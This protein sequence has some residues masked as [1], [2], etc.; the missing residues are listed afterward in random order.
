MTD[1][2][3]ALAPGTRLDEFEIQRVL[4]SGGFG[5]TYLA[6]DLRL[7]RL[8]A[9]KEYLPLMFGTRRRD[10]T[11]GPKSGTDAG[12]DYRWGL[13]RFLKEGQKL[14]QCDHPHVVR[15]YR[16]L[17]AWGTAYLVMEY[18]EGPDGRA[19]SLKDEFVAAGTLPESRVRAILDALT[20]GLAVVHA[21]GLVHRDIKPANVMLRPD[22]SPVLIDFG[23]AR[24]VVTRQTESY[25]IVTDG[26]AAWEQY[27]GDRSGQGP[28]TDIYALGA[29]AYEAL[30]GEVPVKAPERV[31]EDPV[32]PLSEVAVQ[33]VS[34]GLAA[35]IDAALRVFRKER[36][37]SLEAWRALLAEGATGVRV[38]V[39]SSSERPE[40]G[41][42]S[43]REGGAAAAVGGGGSARRWW[44]VGAAAAL[45]AGVA[46]L[47]VP[48]NGTV[49][50]EE[51]AA[52]TPSRVEEIVQPEALLPV[53]PS[54]EPEVPARPPEASPSPAAVEEAL[55]LDRADRR[56]IQEGLLA[57][58]FDP[59]A[60]DGQFGAGTRAALREWQAV[61]QAAETGYLDAASASALRSTAEGAAR[62]VAQR[63]AELAAEAQRQ[64][65]AAG[66]GIAAAGD[67]RPRPGA[68]FRSDETCAGKPAGA[69][70]WMEIAQQPGCYVRNSN[71]Q[72]GASVT[73]TGECAGGLAHGTGTLTWVSDGNQETSTGRL[74]NG[75]KNGNWVLRF[76]NSQVEE[77]PYVD[78]EKN[79]NWV[80][81][82]VVNGIA[83]IEEG[84]YVD[85]EKNG[86]W[87]LRFGNSQVEE[88][89]YVDDEKNGNWVI[90]G[91]ANGIAAIQEGPFVD[92]KK[93]GNWVIRIANGTVEEGPYVDDEKNGNWVFRWANGIVEEGPFVDDEKNGNWVHRGFANGTVEEGPYVDDKKNGNWVIRYPSGEVEDFRLVDGE[94]VAR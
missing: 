22:G 15:V 42:G 37:Q 8:V 43:T 62:V 30:S 67:T 11:V 81:R 84:P 39:G 13:S 79:G 83:V 34:G 3:D 29:V 38:G 69:A 58:G 52:V 90:R 80:I 88:G 48:R 85:D 65:E 57:A 27:V 12:E 45:L 25:L 51:G 64:A 86:N 1:T 46:A 61:R 93:N 24:P 47:G 18:V 50:E 36:P 72:T 60:A 44:L 14:A 55:G 92:G 26:Y 53:D 41:V 10:G 7:D 21:A 91:V 4:G 9:V 40:V 31:E 19:Q 68:E 33:P 20:S 59:G 2:G 74:Q 82:G 6:R 66:A 89:P 56:L 5:V 94:I 23:A 49:P 16:D 75:E 28:W 35:A 54:E 70:C 71:L 73:W 87:V 78:D 76:G 63:Q 32:R 17:E 77:G